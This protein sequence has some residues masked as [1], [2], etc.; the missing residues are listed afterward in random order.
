MQE[1]RYRT[2]ANRRNRTSRNTT[3]KPI[4]APPQFSRFPTT[5][6]SVFLLKSLTSDHGVAHSAWALALNRVRIDGSHVCTA[7]RKSSNGVLSPRITY[8]GVS[9]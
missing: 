2:A 5:G 8:R 1:K 6:D 4:L 3:E 9:I 7:A